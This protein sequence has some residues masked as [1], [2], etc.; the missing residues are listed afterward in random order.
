MKLSYVVVFERLPGNYGAY[1]PD[2]PGC[3]STGKTWDEMQQMIR[4]AIVFHIEGMMGDGGWGM[5][6]GGWGMGNLY[7]S[8]ERPH[9]RQWH[10][11]PVSSPRRAWQGP[12]PRQSWTR[13]KWT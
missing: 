8:P 11:T 2:L 5:G 12:L 13:S 10:G 3:I 7:Q 9:R 6:D 4:E 1:V